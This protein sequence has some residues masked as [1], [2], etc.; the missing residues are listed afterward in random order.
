[1]SKELTGMQ[2]Q[3]TDALNMEQAYNAYIRT[4]EEYCRKYNVDVIYPSTEVE[5]LQ[6]IINEQLQV[7]IKNKKLLTSNKTS[8]SSPTKLRLSDSD[9]LL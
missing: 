6:V 5:R 2:K 7:I 1:M 3:L 8:K 9:L 4:K